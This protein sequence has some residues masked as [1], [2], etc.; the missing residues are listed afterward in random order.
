VM[1]EA[2]M[3]A[4]EASQPVDQRIPGIQQFAAAVSAKPHAGGGVCC[5]SHTCFSTC[6]CY[7]CCGGPP[8]AAV[9]TSP[10]PSTTCTPPPPPPH[11]PQV[12]ER[13]RHI[14]SQTYSD[15]LDHVFTEFD[16]DDDDKL[17]ASEVTAAL[18][19][20]GVEAEERL[21]ARFIECELRASAC[22]F[23]H[24]WHLSASGVPAA[25]KLH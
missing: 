5:E 18:R 7:C 13:R 2:F 6:C 3:H 12:W 4:Y 25:V 24:M 10:A 15:P 8:I 19:S 1:H 22:V 14:P 21:I 16:T 17:S 20:R 11:P 23:P 9:T